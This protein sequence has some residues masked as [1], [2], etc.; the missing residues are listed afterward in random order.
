MDVCFVGAEG[1][2]TFT[3]LVSE[4]VDFRVDV[5][6]RVRGVREVLSDL[7]ATVVL[8]LALVRCF[9]GFDTASAAESSTVGFS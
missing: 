3:L 8:L 7:E 2:S 6:A 4:A 1:A 5:A 9:D